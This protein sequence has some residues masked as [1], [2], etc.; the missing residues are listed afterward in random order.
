MQSFLAD[1]DRKGV[2]SEGERTWVANVRDMAYD[3]EDIIDKFMYHMN[4]QRIGGRYSWI[5]HHS[6]YFPKNLWVRRQTATKIQKINGKIKGAIPER[7]QR[8]GIDRIEGTSSKDNQKWVIRSMTQLTSIGLTNVKAA[9]EMDLCDSIHNMKLMR[10]LCVMVTNAEETLRMDALS[11]P[12][13]NLQKLVLAGKLEKVPLWFHSLQSLTYLGLHWSRLE[14]DLLPQIA[15]LPHLRHLT[16]TNAYVGKQLC[17]STGFLQL[18]RLRIRNFPQLNE[19]IIEKGVMPNLKSLY[20]ISCMQLNTVPKGIEYLQNLQELLLES[21]SMEL[22]N[23]IE[24]EGSVDFP[25][26][27]HIP[28]IYIY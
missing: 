7:N 22:Q 10:Q 4:R 12:P 23:R 18:T 9:D 20:I 26:V 3:V 1:A 14:E 13:T 25:K 11:S 15:A 27:Q 8:Y 17:F 19:I 2:G 5:L 24:G 16:L 21:V 28:N 6:I